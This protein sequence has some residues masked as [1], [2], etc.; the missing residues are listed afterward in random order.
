MLG[1]QLEY[2]NSPEPNQFVPDEIEMADACPEVLIVYE[3]HESKRI[4][5]FDFCSPERC[6]I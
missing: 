6:K 3:G 4:M 5:I 2:M 1:R